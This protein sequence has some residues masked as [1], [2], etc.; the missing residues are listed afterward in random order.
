M[1]SNTLWQPN[2]K[3]A[4]S[5]KIAIALG[6]FIWLWPVTH[7]PLP[8]FWPN[9]VAWACT[10]LIATL[11][12]KSPNR[13]P[14]LVG[15]WLVASAVSSI[16]ALLQYFDLEGE[17]SSF[18]AMAQPGYGY[19]NTRQ[20]NHLA[21]L[22]TVGMAALIWCR[23]TGRLLGSS[24]LLGILFAA[25]L[26]TTASRG[27]ALQMLLVGGIGLYWNREKP[28]NFAGW[29]GCLIISYI[30]AVTVFPW[31]LQAIQGLEGGRNFFDRWAVENTCSSRKILWGNVLDIIHRK[32]FTGWGWGNLG[33]ASYDTLHDGV[34]FCT[35]FTNAHNLPLHFA[36]ELGIPLAAALSITSC[37][38]ALYLRPWATK[39]PERQLAIGVVLVLLVHSLLEFPLWFGNFQSMLLFSIWIYRDIQALPEKTKSMRENSSQQSKKFLVALA[40]FYLAALAWDYTRVSLLYLPF[41]D[42]LDAYKENT[43]EKVKFSIFHKDQVLFA[44]VVATDPNSA[45]AQMLLNGA[46]QA[47][48]I[49]PE[50]RIIERV[51]VS[52]SIL[53]REDLVEYHSIRYEANWPAEYA[54]WRSAQSTAR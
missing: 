36:A 2:K 9:W 40:S 43:L 39:E 44:L 20:P 7:G 13:T 11:L 50:P 45:N 8:Q 42:R 33:F 16:I 34:R 48:H 46:L 14:S 12:A 41:A 17:L 31:L 4:L 28:S 21:S 35:Y 52:A 1:I 37:A 23:Q 26:A 49:S 38:V 24:W 22:L 15:G 47:L 3:P 27:G 53:G 19:A 54:K 30:T 51:I 32:P 25:G 18:I 6:A 5:D 29:F 10:L